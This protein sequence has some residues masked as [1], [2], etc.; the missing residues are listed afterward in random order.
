MDQSGTTVT[1]IFVTN[2]TV[3]VA[4]I[5]DSR[6]ILSTQKGGELS[7]EQLTIDHVASNDEEGKLVESR[8]GQILTG[9]G[10]PR[11]NGKLAIT[12]SIGDAKLAPY[13]SRRPHVVAMTRTEVKTR[14]WDQG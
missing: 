4:N 2:L 1:T 11:V 3:I 12:R 9:I 8:G 14:C 7:Y 6:A 10:I 13:L 5:G